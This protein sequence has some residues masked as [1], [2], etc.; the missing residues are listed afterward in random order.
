MLSIYRPTYPSS[1][2]QH[3]SHCHLPS[4]GLLWAYLLLWLKQQR[5]AEVALSLQEVQPDS[6]TQDS[7]FYPFLLSKGLEKEEAKAS[8]P[9]DPGQQD[10]GYFGQFAEAAVCGRN[11]YVS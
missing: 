1:V 10:A 4:P 5:K 9:G 8:L 7:D 11:H 3:I 6:G 2:S